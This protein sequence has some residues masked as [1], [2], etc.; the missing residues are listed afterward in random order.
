[1]K[2]ANR[3]I[4]QGHKPYIIAE[5]SGNHNGDINRAIALIKAAKEAGAD[6][7]KLQT[8]TADTITINHDSEEF[9]IRGG[10]FG[11]ALSFMIC[12]SK[13]IHLGSGTRH[14]LMQ[15]KKLV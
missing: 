1:M 3:Q 6:A 8:Y 11:M 9:M 12:M 4:G 14:Y 13:H 10:G 5:M 15:L 2:I 7:V